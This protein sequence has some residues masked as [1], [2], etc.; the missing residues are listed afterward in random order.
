MPLPVGEPQV[1]GTVH[2]LD[3]QGADV[4]SDDDVFGV[5]QGVVLGQRLR[6]RDVEGG[7]CQGLIVQRLDQR[8]LVDDRSPGD[9]DDECAF[10]AFLSRLKLRGIG[11]R[12]RE[13]GEF[14]LA[15]EMLRCG[16]Q[17]K[18]D[19]KCIEAGAQKCMERFLARAA[20]PRAGNRAF[21]VTRPRNPVTGIFARFR[22][23]ARTGRVCVDGSTQG[24]KDS[25]S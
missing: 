15:E 5:P 12:R 18:C 24:G 11:R 3:A 16:R 21:W 19:E 4:G 23:C 14:F 25:C 17:G 13:K 6:V 1:V 2:I 22:C 10:G 9:V 7:A 8:G 20:V